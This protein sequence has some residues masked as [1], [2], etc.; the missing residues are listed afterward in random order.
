MNEHPQSKEEHIN[1]TATD[2]R[3]ALTPKWRKDTNQIRNVRVT[4]AKFLSAPVFS[5]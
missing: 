2:S 5:A 1:M 4:H 3:S